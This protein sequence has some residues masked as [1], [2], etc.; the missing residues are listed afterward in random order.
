MQKYIFI[1]LVILLP[2]S[3]AYAYDRELNEARKCINLYNQFEQK[4]KLPE[5]TLY[6]IG[7]HET[8]KIHS[9]LKRPI[10]WPWTVNFEGKGYY[11]N[12]KKEASDFVKKQIRLGNNNIDVGCMQVNLKHHPTAFRSI[13]QAFTPRYNIAYAGKFLLEKY[14]ASGSWGEAISHY[15]SS[16]PIK[17]GQYKDKVLKI[18][19]NMDK[20]KSLF[21]GK[22]SINSAPRNRQKLAFKQ[23]AKRYKSDIMIEVSRDQET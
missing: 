17:G 13:D 11:F 22:K 1:F 18:A 19:R 21:R 8:S 6:A 16:N 23:K 12:S 9:T 10:S 14:K 3:G 7:L 4:L 20:H 2:I 15:H 5:D